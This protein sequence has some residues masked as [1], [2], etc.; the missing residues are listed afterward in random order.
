M[1]HGSKTR[2][3]AWEGTQP[4]ESAGATL[5]QSLS[6]PYTSPTRVAF[7]NVFSQRQRYARLPPV[8]KRKLST[9]APPTLQART[10]GL[11]GTGYRGCSNVDLSGAIYQ[12]SESAPGTTDQPSC[13]RRT[14]ITV[15]DIEDMHWE[16]KCQPRKSNIDIYTGT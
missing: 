2:R 15:Q 3:Q 6:N 5:S 13:H 4:T 14:K 10:S 7:H 16:R 11:S 9:V 8:S 12:R 1:M